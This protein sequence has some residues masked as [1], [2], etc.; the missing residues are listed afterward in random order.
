MEKK[1]QII[2]V[3]EFVYV[4][5]DEEIK[6]GD[7]YLE[8]AS[9]TSWVII[10][11]KANSDTKGYNKKIIATTNPELT[12]KVYEDYKPMG[13]NSFKFVQSLPKPTDQFI[14]QWIAKGCP[15]MIN[16]EYEH[17]NVE[18]NL[19][20]KCVRENE[21]QEI[22][23]ISSDNTIICSFIEDDWESIIKD[24]PDYAINSEI[25]LLAY[26]TDNYNPPT[27]NMKNKLYLL[28]S[29]IKKYYKTHY[30]LCLGEKELAARMNFGMAQFVNITSGT[31]VESAIWSLGYDIEEVPIS[32]TNQ[33]LI[34]KVLKKKKV[35]DFITWLNN[36]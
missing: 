21:C 16:V 9:D 32:E 1:R 24:M 2:Q 3:G 30:F 28:K 17:S 20:C 31:I 26:L 8:R 29:S 19:L 5:T 22:L 13:E 33:E 12:I 15:E 6:E 34:N 23:K 14:Q 18:C 11:K 7:W 10:P 35:S 27:K 36:K 25:G 4:L